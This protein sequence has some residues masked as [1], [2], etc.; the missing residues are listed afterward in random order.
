MK[1]FIAIQELTSKELSDYLS[2]GKKLKAER[3]ARGNKPILKNKTLAMIFQKPSLRTRV[4][5]DMAMLHLGGQALYLLQT[6]SGWGSAEHRR[7]FSG[8]VTICRWD[9]GVSLRMIMSL[10]L[11]NIRAFQ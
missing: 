5:F 3:R 10:S 2:M 7:C 4:S 6:R 11:Q 1:H 8:L 9:Y